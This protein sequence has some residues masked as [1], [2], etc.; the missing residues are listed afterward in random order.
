MKRAEKKNTG[1]YNI[2]GALIVLALV[3]LTIVV[4]N[5]LKNR[6]DSYVIP[7]G[8]TVYDVNNEYIPLE[9][10]AKLYKKADGDFYLKIGRQN[11]IIFETIIYSIMYFEVCCLSLYQSFGFSSVY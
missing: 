3:G 8:S 11:D 6:S 10:D 7:A 1:I 2:F 5:V 9:E 4:I